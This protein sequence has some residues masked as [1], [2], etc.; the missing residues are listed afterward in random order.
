MVW[1]RQT[2]V[3]GEG[4]DGGALGTVTE[5]D[6][7]GVHGTAKGGWRRGQGERRRW[8]EGEAVSGEGTT[9]AVL[10]AGA[11]GCTGHTVSSSSSQPPSTTAVPDGTTSTTSPCLPWEW[12]G[13]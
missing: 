7:G 4:A 2:V 6:A 12:R 13:E 8:G 1:W 5:D 9:V 11:R 3:G 10:G